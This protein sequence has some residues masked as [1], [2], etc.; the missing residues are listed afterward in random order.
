MKYKKRNLYTDANGRNIILR[1]EDTDDELR[2]DLHA[3]LPA[4]T[5]NTCKYG[6]NFVY[7][8]FAESPFVNSNGIPNNAR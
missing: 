6:D 2:L 3:V 4:W 7:L 1:F 5:R 8:A